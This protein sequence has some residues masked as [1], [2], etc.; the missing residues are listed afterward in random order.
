MPR[1]TYFFAIEMTRRRFASIISLFALRIFASAAT[2]FRLISFNCFNGSATAASMA[3]SFCCSA[4]MAG[5]LRSSAAPNSLDLAAIRMVQS[6]SVSWPG[7]D[8][9]N[10]SRGM[11]LFSST[12]C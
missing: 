12:I 7:N 3:I 10:S 2:I 11:P 4:W 9:I 8:S 1:L 6:R 5:R